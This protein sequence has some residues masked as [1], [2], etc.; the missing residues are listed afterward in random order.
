V[1]GI[2]VFEKPP[3]FDNALVLHVIVADAERKESETVRKA[4]KF[5]EVR[6]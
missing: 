5:L 2:L 1:S 4:L 3:V 6:L